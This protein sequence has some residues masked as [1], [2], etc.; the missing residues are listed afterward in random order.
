MQHPP[1]EDPDKSRDTNRIEKF[2]HDLGKADESVLKTLQENSN[3]NSSKTSLSYSNTRGGSVIFILLLVAIG[4][5]GFLNS[6]NDR[7]ADP[8]EGMITNYFLR[9]TAD[10]VVFYDR[11]NVKLGVLEPGS[12]VWGFKGAERSGNF[13]DVMAEIPE[14]AVGRVDERSLR[15]HLK[16]TTI[17]NCKTGFNADNARLYVAIE[18]AS[19]H[20]SP[21][22]SP[23]ATFLESGSCLFIDPTEEAQ[24]NRNRILVVDDYAHKDGF[25]EL[26]DFVQNAFVEANKIRPMRFYDYQCYRTAMEETIL[27]TAINK[28]EKEPAM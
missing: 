16:G 13:L 25:V 26:G 12:C 6:G 21:V 22:G 3:T 14:Q 15:Q 10:R 24:N 17:Y 1:G 23:R 20:R 19:L 9:S 11:D 5:V 28:G 4:A 7:Q 27:P 2:F 8:H 18:D